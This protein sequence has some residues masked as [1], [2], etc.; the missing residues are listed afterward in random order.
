MTPAEV[1]D[2]H[3]RL[4]RCTLE[5]E[6]SRA[7]WSHPAFATAGDVAT[8]AFEESWFGARSLPRVKV[9]L[10]NFR[11]RFDAYPHALRV[12]GEWREMEPGTR[13][14]ICHWHVQLSDPIYRGFAGAFLVE[15][16][17][18]ARAEVTRDMVTR[19]VGD[20]GPGRWTTKTRIQFASQLLATAKAAG[21]VKNLQG[22]RKLAFP[23]VGDDALTYL[24]YLLRGVQFEGTL[25]DNP[26]LASVGLMPR[27]AED[28]MRALSALHFKRQGALVDFGW[29]YRDLEDWAHATVARHDRG[30]A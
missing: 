26:Y 19:W 17:E 4:Q 9:L 27:L 7:W 28:R 15:R 13:A 8:R 10:S 21:L 2:I 6:N 29:V 30:A 11:A 3:T 23:R 24:L 18:A 14:L 20:Q 12:L 25:L 1:K 16:H 22:P 5:I